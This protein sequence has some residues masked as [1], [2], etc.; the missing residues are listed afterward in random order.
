MKLDNNPFEYEAANNLDDE[1]IADYY[2][3]DFNYSR[4]IQSKR[5]VF[6]VGERGSGKTM[7]LLFNSWRIQK[8][9]AKRREEE[10]SLSTIGVYIPCNTPLTH[11]TEY[12]LLEDDFLRSVLSE[13]F[14]VL[15]VAYGLAD[16]LAEIPD[17]LEG[18]NESLLRSEA[19]FV[20]GAALPEEA[21]FFEAV[22]Q[23]IQRE[24]LDTQ[25]KINSERRETF[26]E[27]T[28]SFASVFVPILNMCANKIPKLKDSHFLLLLDDAHAL[29]RYQARALN[30]WI[31]YRDHSLFSFKVAVAKIGTQTKVTSSGGS[32][33]E[34]HDYT[35]INLEASLQN[36]NTDFYQLAERIIKQRLKNISVS[37]T[38]KEFFPVN[39]TMENDLRRSERAVREKAIRKFGDADEK[40]KAITDYVYKY[41]RAHYF[42]NR[43][44]KA[45]RPPYSGFET[46]VFISTG[47]VRNLLEPCYWMFDSA[48]SKAKETRGEE[49]SETIL[50]IPSNIQAE[51]IQRL[52]E[53]KWEWARNNISQDIEDCSTEDGLRAFQLLDALAVHFRYR[54]KHHQSEPC[55][56]S[57]TISKRE[58]DVMV[59]LKHLIEILRK[60]QLLY[61]RSGPS[62]DSGQ[63]EPYYVPNKILW[64]VR[65][66]DP[67]GQHARVSIP[68]D[69]LWKAAETGKIDPKYLKDDGQM[70]LWNEEQ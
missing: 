29:N 45:N 68:A 67:H 6:L 32:I 1:M 2:I 28:F 65:G 15:S 56:L 63:I 3:D 41:R 17:I 23:F 14:L 27:N 4:F 43:S 53:R 47:V 46:L 66:L 49:S 5:N 60:A 31:A 13:H 18:A 51:V 19:N 35:E 54:L 40:S 11:K 69:V 37:A 38:P 55:A 61:I 16:T 50:N 9:L 39:T 62:K 44:S 59:N 20:L 26:Y 30:S 12:E 57:F 48:V 8:L 70:E 64:P 25:R 52:S 33:L 24:L 7:A 42:K 10:L 58:L 34:G 36:R 22:K 21:S